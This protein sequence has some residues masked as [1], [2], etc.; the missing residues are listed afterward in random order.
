MAYTCI[1]VIVI[2]MYYHCFAIKF[3]LLQMNIKKHKSIHV[4]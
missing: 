3:Y 2:T 4:K 1:D